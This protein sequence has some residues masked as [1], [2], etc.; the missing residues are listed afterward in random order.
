M[1][2]TAKQ[3]SPATHTTSQ[4]QCLGTM[5]MRLLGTGI[6]GSTLIRLFD[7]FDR[8][9][10]G[11]RDLGLR[12]FIAQFVVVGTHLAQGLVDGVDGDDGRVQS[13]SLWDVR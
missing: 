5:S 6:S 7:D 1:R 10:E 13:G 8:Q 4:G 3:I 11:L 12:F 9:A 2:V